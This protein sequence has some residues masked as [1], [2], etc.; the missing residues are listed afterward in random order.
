MSLFQSIDEINNHINLSYDE[1]AEAEISD[2]K[3]YPVYMSTRSATDKI[4][5]LDEILNRCATEL[6]GEKILEKYAKRIRSEI[7]DNFCVNGGVKGNI[8]G[9]AFNK[10]VMECIKAIPKLNRDRRF[11]IH[12]EKDHEIVNTDERPDWTIFDLISRKTIIGMNQITLWGGGAQTNRGSKY[13]MNNKSNDRVKH[14]AVVC[15]KPELKSMNN[16]DFKLLQKGFSEKTLCYTGK[17]G[18]EDIILRWFF[19]EDYRA[20]ATWDPEIFYD[21][22]KK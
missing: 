7:I 22:W 9:Q 8:R 12:F 5:L 11:E 19:P 4:N 21:L 20:P 17:C 6:G 3:L 18:L 10:Y 14:L 15:R 2:E 16:K 13:I 1:K